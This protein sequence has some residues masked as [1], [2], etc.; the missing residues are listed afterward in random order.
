MLVKTLPLPLAGL[1]LSAL[2]AGCVTTGL[3]DINS[4]IRFKDILD[5]SS[6]TIMMGEAASSLS[7][8]AAST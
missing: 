5:G 4:K 1:F 6:T 2:L 3:F 8:G 7:I